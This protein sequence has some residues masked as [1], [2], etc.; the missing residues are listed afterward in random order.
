MCQFDREYNVEQYALEIDL[1]VR[2]ALTP[3]SIPSAL[4]N[5]VRT[6]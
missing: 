5:T 6:A 3:R 4:K 1:P 2:L